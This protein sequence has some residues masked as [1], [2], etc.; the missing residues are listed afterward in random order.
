MLRLFSSY[1][2]LWFVFDFLILQPAI[3]LNLKSKNT[4]HHEM[5]EYC[6]MLRLLRFFI[7]LLIGCLV[8]YGCGR[9]GDPLPRTRVRPAACPVQWISHRILEIKIPFNDEFGN[10]LVGIEKVRIYYLPLSYDRPNG[11]LIITKGQV[12][13]ERKLPNV[14]SLGKSVKLD[15]KQFSYPPGWL[16]VVAVR[17]GDIIGVPSETLVW[18]DLLIY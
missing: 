9:K 18:P 12:I 17:V 11:D 4:R 1:K 6:R 2:S 8:P 16:V 13:I 15:L 7:L 5:L 3:Q 14:T 10:R